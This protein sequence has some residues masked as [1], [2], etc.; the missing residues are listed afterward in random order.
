LRSWLRRAIASAGLLLLC[1]ACPGQ[2]LAQ[3]A[4]TPYGQIKLW[5]QALTR[6]EGTL[7]ESATILPGDSID[8]QASLNA[9]L[10]SAQQLRDSEGRRLP[11]LR[12]QLE[13]LGPPPGEGQPPE[14]EDVAR[15][16]RQITNEISLAEGRIKQSD[17]AIARANAVLAEIGRKEQAEIQGQIL[18]QGP[19]PAGAATWTIAMTQDLQVVTDLGEAIGDWWSQLRQRTIDRVSLLATPLAL[20]VAMLLAYLARRAILRS[21]GPN[22]AR[23]S[24][25]YARRLAAAAASTVARILLP[26]IVVGAATILFLLS[27]PGGAPTPL[28]AL[29]NDVASHLVWFLVVTGLA[30]SAFSPK[31]PAW[32]IMPVPAEAAALLAGQTVIG[33]ALILLLA[34][35]QSMLVNPAT[36]LAGLHV[37]SVIA[38]LNALVAVIVFMPALRSRYWTIDGGNLGSGLSRALRG[39]AALAIMVAM[40]AAIFGYANLS[41]HVLTCL[42]ITAVIIGIVFLA[43]AL[44]GETLRALLAPDGRFFASVSRA[45][46]VSGESGRRLIFWIRLL[47]E[48]VIWPPAIY[49]LLISYGLSP[50]LLNAWTIQAAQGVNIGSLTISPIDLGTALVTIILGFLAVGSLKRW[51]RER[52]MPNTGLDRGLQN[53]V[54]TGVGYLGGIAVLMLGVI[55]LGIDLSNLALVAGALSVGMGFGLKTIVENFVAG[56]LLLIERPIKAGDWIV[57]GATEG[58]VKSISVRSTE[59]ETFDRSAVIVPNSEL[60]ASP[61]I[62]WTHKNR[63]A[64]IIVKVTIATLNNPR[65]AEAIMLRAAVAHARVMR[66]PEPSVVFRAMGTTLQLELR[67]FV[68]DT[69]YYL[70]VLSDLN[71]AVFEAF[72]AEGVTLPV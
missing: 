12:V 16:R 30:I 6:L 19:S 41:Q 62:N 59:I 28:W 3:Q 61:V 37:R 67:C 65:Q 13:S 70:P 56:I 66:H 68:A 64:R 9:I 21:W 55:A 24:P 69:D 20:I 26:A 57:V 29:A 11:Q 8:Y 72:R 47:S 52:V 23:A 71:F 27:L 5:D 46:G 14:V 35:L 4:A 38:F 43:R 18:T 50:S 2:A 25:G 48:L 53:S 54:S 34:I 15:K 17:L 51:M 63:V 42:S 1:L 58:I 39:G 49:S 40:A 10:V 45:T 32:R 7:A 44:V 22:A 60:I 33:S 31:L 36:G